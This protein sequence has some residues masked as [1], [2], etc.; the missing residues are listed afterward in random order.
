MDI[1]TK[2]VPSLLLL[3]L[4]IS[5]CNCNNSERKHGSSQILPQNENNMA[6]SPTNL[7]EVIVFLGNTGVG[8]STLCNSIFG[9]A[10]FNSGISLGT[11]MTEHTQ[12]H[13]YNNKLYI[14]TP[15]LNDV[16][17]SEKAAKEIEE[18]L[19]KNNNY[20][21]V[22]V[23]TLEEGRIRATDLVT[24][25]IVCNAIKT[26]FEYG[27]IFNKVTKEVINKINEKEQDKLYS[28]LAL[29]QKKPLVTTIL[30]KDNDIAGEDNKYFK[31]NNNREKL[32]ECINKIKAFRIDDKN[33]QQID[34][35]DF[36]NKVDEMEKK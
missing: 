13:I 4:L 2:K 24:I 36:Q 3:I 16:E 23:A 31:S 8:K 21:I 14:D 12:E 22:F 1:V 19:K 26:N 7:D 27:L 32:F 25:N 5:S 28:Y 35:R 29:L 10:I 6:G 15:G 17:N 20:K 9:Q 11:G 33:I 34:I 18:A 30:T